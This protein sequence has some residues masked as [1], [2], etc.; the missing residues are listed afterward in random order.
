MLK[1]SLGAGI[2]GDANT[3]PS[4]G[5]I[6]MFHRR[7]WRLSRRKL[8]TVTG[9]SMA[10]IEK[11]ER[12]ERPVSRENLDTILHALGIHQLFRDEY[13]ELAFQPEIVQKR[14]LAGENTFPEEHDVAGLDSLNCPAALMA[15]ASGDLLA[16]NDWFDR[17]L[18]GAR[19]TARRPR[20]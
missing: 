4:I 3:T 1:S 2:P 20:A 9:I 7:W 18:P 10:Q 17:A 5:Q 15:P 13:A 14:L 16:T 12:G 8:A 11:M 6:L 19:Q